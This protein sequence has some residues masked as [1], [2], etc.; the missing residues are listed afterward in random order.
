MACA[1][2]ALIVLDE[3]NDPWLSVL[4]LTIAVASG[5]LIALTFSWVE[6]NP[7]ALVGLSLQHPARVAISWDEKVVVRRTDYFG[8][9]CVAVWSIDGSKTVTIPLSIAKA[10]RFHD[11]IEPFTDASH[12]L[13]RVK[14]YAA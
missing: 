8:I 14:A 4:V 1:V 10:Q 2:V 7:E 11:A 6:V 12:P 5:Y 13:R 3:R 9:P